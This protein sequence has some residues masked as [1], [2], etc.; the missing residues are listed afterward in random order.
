MKKTLVAVVALAACA[1]TQLFAQSTKEGVMAFALTGQGQSSVSISATKSNDGGWN[2]PPTVYKTFTSKLNAAG[3]IKAISVVLHDGNAN[4]YSSKAQLVMVQGELGG[5]FNIQPRLANNRH[6]D[7]SST[8]P[9]GLPDQFVRTPTYSSTVSQTFP[10]LASGRHYQ[11]NPISGKFPVGHHQPWGQIYV[12]DTGKSPML[13]E[14]VTFFFAITVEEC[15]D[16][17]YLNSF[18]SDSK[19]TFKNNTQSGPPCCTVPVD[20]LGCGKDKYYMTLSFDN[21]WNNPYLNPQYDCWIGYFSLDNPYSGITG[22]DVFGLG[23]V[24]DGLTPDFLPY[25]EF[26]RS[27]LGTA[28]PYELRFTL[29]GIMTYAWCLKVNASDIS[30]DFIG[31]ASYDATGYGFAGL[32]CTLYDGL[33]TVNEKISKSSTCCVDQP[34]YDSWYGPGWNLAQDPWYDWFQSPVNVP[35]SLSFHAGFDGNYEIGNQWGSNPEPNQ[36]LYTLDPENPYSY[37]PVGL[38]YWSTLD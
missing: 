29:N 11:T 15:Y 25:E 17:F 2:S 7:E 1:G 12:K 5:F 28:Q 8:L 21:T 10:A 4:Y 32:I 23:T 20:L 24:G 30:P 31:N 35:A 13:C 36:R 22:L 27:G 3:I 14:N 37:A 33:M 6:L 9:T 34:W 18:I 19:F 38:E 26:I 16:C